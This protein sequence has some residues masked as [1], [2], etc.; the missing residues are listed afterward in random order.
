M[1]RSRAARLAA[2][3][4]VCDLRLLIL[5]GSPKKAGSLSVSTISTMLKSVATKIAHNSTIPSLAGNSDL[6]SLQDL[7]TAEKSVLTSCVGDCAL[8]PSSNE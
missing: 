1:K 6:R 8:S 4:C 2:A 3:V 5:L 7:I